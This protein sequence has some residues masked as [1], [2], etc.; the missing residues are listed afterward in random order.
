[1]KKQVVNILLSVFCGFSGAYIFQFTPLKYSP[2]GNS[3]QQE[4]SNVSLTNHTSEN[5]FFE[6]V[7]KSNENRTISEIS[8]FKL[9]SAKSMESVVYIK[10][11]SGSEYERYSWFDLFFN[12]RANERKVVGSGSGVIFSN[13]GYIVTNNHVIEGS[14]N[15]EVIHHKKTYSATIVGTDPSTD[16]A[17][18]KVDASGL[19]AIQVGNSSNLRV[20]EW[21][22]AVGN[23]FNLESTATSGIVSAKGRRINILEDIFPIESFIQ[24]DAAI[25]P[26]NSG[27]ALVNTEG[28]LVGINTAILSK[29]GSYAGYGFAVPSDIVVKV[30]DDLKQYGEVQKA[31]IGAEIVD[32]NEKIS[33]QLN[34]DNLNGVVVATLENSGAA[35]SA[36]IAVGDVIVNIEG[37]AINSKSNFDEQMSYYSPGDNVSITYTREKEKYTTQ[38]TL[39]NIEGTTGIVKRNVFIADKL[40][41]TFEGVPKLEKQRLRLTSGVRISEVN[42]GLI[43]RMDL[44]EGFIVT[45]INNYE[46]N[47][48]KELSEILERIRGRVIIEFVNK[49]GKKG[50]YSYAF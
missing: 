16:L 4:M 43:S 45:K 8:D 31:F 3:Y 37:V 24:T 6:E 20:G 10:T 46:V 17:L 41:A 2:K 21:V 25:N 11:V 44:G 38:V 33:N 19:P 30:V 27:G 42:R 29:T 5:S 13:D 7:P 50:A 26:G 9:A 14:D 39:T 1:M 49:D 15:I 47:D 12:G 32:L 48:P 18:L 36:G 23:P 35:K 22:L 40:G 28:E 34:I